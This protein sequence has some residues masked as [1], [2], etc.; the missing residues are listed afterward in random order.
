[1]GCWSGL[2]FEKAASAS[3][4]YFRLPLVRH[5]SDWRKQ[6]DNASAEREFD[7]MPVRAEM[8]CP[9]HGSPP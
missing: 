2:W 6:P 3:L 1:M 8:G 4:N 7:G 9:P 5:R